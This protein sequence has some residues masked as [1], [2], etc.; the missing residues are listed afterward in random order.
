[1]SKIVY[2]KL[3][4]GYMQGYKCSRKEKKLQ[5]KMFNETVIDYQKWHEKKYHDRIINDNQARVMLKRDFNK[6]RGIVK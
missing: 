6:I 2:W 3:V 1:M 4:Y 5:K